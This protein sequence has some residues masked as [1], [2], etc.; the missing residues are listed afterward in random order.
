MDCIGQSTKQESR[1]MRRIVLGLSSLMALFV[2]FLATGSPAF[3]RPA[4]GPSDNF[5]PAVVH[6]A[7]GLRAW[8]VAVIVLAGLVVV[9]VATV[10]GAFLRVSHR[11]APTPASS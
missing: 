4:G 10:A 6:H 7:A 5:A 8:Q 11:A 2:S 9:G 1:K 3:A